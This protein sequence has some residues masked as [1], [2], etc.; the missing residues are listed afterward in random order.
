[1]N[2]EPVNSR[3]ST[4]IGSVRL[5]NP[6]I[7]GSG[8]PTMTASGIRAALK[9][10]AGAVMAKS[11]NESPKA[12]KQLDHTDYML[13]DGAFRPIEWTSSPPVDAQLFCRSGLNQ[14]D[15]DDWIGTLARLDEEARALDSYVVG[16]LILADLTQC[17]RMARR[18][19]EAGL[20]TL[21]VLISAVHG[22]QASRDAI[23]VIR[24][25]EEVGEVVRELRKAVRIPLWIKLPG[26]DVTHF[27]K[28]A[29]DAGA[30]AVNFIDR[31]LAMVPDLATRSPYLGTMGAIGGR[32]ALPLA[33]RWIAETRLK[34]G[35]DL[36]VIGCNGARDGY[37]VA[38]MLLAGARAV[39]M[40]TAV[41]LHGTSVLSQAIAELDG[42]LTEQGVTVDEIV[43]E[44]A[45]KLT[46]Y[47]DQPS[48]P[49]RWK[50]FVHEEAL[51]P[52]K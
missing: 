15:V 11:V 19:E 22:E 51:D 20:R 6:V 50:G 35:R 33:C 37:D 14:V 13:F 41:M 17:I 8:E 49:G 42:Y 23:A 34:V 30:D 39:E 1:M 44:A 31:S 7:C 5:K 18:M 4:S 40:T 25:S 2:S 29:R 12:R 38:R 27:A 24:T 43:G 10:G 36:P 26:H 28:A 48:R 16:H 21:T 3:L 9:A 32:W 45:D 46:A 47:T 52:A